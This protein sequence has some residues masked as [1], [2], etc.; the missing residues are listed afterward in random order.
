MLIVSN[1]TLSQMEEVNFKLYINKAGESWI[2]DRFRAEWYKANKNT[3]RRISNADIVWIISPWTWQKLDKKKLD[4]L[5]TVCTIHHIDETKVD[6]DY[7]DDFKARDKYV[8]IYHVPSK[9]TEA[10]LNNLTNKPKIQIPFWVDS[11]K[12]FEIKNKQALRSKFGF[13]DNDY[14]VGSFQR[15]TEGYDLISPK[16]SK[17][18][19]LFIQNLNKLKNQIESKNLKV[20]I[21]GYRRQYIIN[22]LKKL[23]IDYTYY[24]KP[25]LKILNELYNCLDLYLVASRVEG[26]PMAIMEC[27]LVKT[28]IVS[29]DVGIS[30]EVLHPTS[31]YEIESFESAIPNINFAYEKAKNFVIKDGM[32]K[33]NEMMV[34]LYES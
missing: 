19:D 10:Q 4:I 33:F 23:E 24:K 29:T 32:N 15:D 2:T 22:E 14:V 13:S 30:T 21:A 28:P 27:A 26:G 17:G 3:T 7:L 6:S 31:I 12:F 1:T 11:Q 9:K 5:K 25:S 16:L 34:N 18:P 20:L 8:D